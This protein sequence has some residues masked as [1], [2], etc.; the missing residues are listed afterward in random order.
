MIVRTRTLP[1]GSL[2]VGA[3][4][5]ALAACAG[6]PPGPSDL[7]DFASRYADAWSSQDPNRLA[8]F[9]AE[10]GSLVVNGTEHDGR[11]AVR[12]TAA[13]FMEAFP[14]MRVEMDSVVDRGDGHAVFYWTWTGTN[15]G[16]GGTGRSVNLQ[17]YEEWTFAADDA[18]AVSDGHY[19]QAE[20]ELQVSGEIE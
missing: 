5:T 13:T 16:P 19:D 11:A 9:Y 3:S 14:D 4:L 17:G 15:T 2:V 7:N 6:E 12:E 18:L 1:I 10:D 8:S 20:Y